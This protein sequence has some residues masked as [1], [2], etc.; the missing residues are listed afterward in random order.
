MSWASILEVI[1]KQIDGQLC[2]PYEHLVIDCEA[3]HSGVMEELGLR[4]AEMKTLSSMAVAVFGWSSSSPA[5]PIVS[6]AVSD[7]DLR[8]RHHDPC[9]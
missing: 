1:Q 8:V 7:P 6:L 3:D 4:R 9:V 2:E 5:G